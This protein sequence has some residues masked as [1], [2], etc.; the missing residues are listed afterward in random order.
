MF[1]CVYAK[2][3]SNLKLKCKK[4]KSYHEKRTAHW[5]TIT[6]VLLKPLKHCL[7]DTTLFRL[8]KLHYS[9]SFL[10]KLANNFGYVFTNHL[11][12]RIHETKFMTHVSFLFSHFLF[13]VNFP[14][15]LK[16]VLLF[17]TVAM[18][19]LYQTL[20]NCGSRKV[21]KLHEESELLLLLLFL[22]LKF[23]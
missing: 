14:L 17:I 4:N 13:I 2:Q 11:D 18:L 21:E 9:L 7:I 1:I 12:C 20:V 15:L 6:S 19:S 22:G 16:I 5:Y 10:F 3:Y 8:L 23:I